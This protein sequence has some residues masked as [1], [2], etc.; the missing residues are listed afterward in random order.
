MN[1]DGFVLRAVGERM[2]KRPETNKILIILSDGK[3]NDVRVFKKDVASPEIREYTGDTAVKDTAAEVRKLRRQGIS[4]LGVFT[5]LETDLLAQQKIYGREFAYIK[6]LKQFAKIVGTYLKK[7]L[8]K[9][10]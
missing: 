9:F 10:S 2:A 5:G 4:V 6:D 3:P 7:E 1:R 8:R